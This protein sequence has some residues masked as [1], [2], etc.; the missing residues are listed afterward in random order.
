M[1]QNAWAWIIIAI[2]GGIFGVPWLIDWLVTSYLMGTGW[3]IGAIATLV[4]SSLLFILAMW[5]P[6]L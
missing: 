4:V 5:R 2:F 6:K 1:T 3:L